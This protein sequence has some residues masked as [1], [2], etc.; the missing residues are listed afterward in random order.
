MEL[1]LDAALDICLA[2]LRQESRWDLLE[3][4]REGLLGGD[5][6]LRAEKGILPKGAWHQAWRVPTPWAGARLTWR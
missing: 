2:R 5:R 6:C 3:D 4:G 1:D